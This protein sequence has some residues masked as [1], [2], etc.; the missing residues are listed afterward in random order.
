MVAA[1]SSARQNVRA[2]LLAPPRPHGKASKTRVGPA[3]GVH[4]DWII[5]K[6]VQRCNLNCT[7]CYVYN[8]GD[9]S[10][11]NRPA[12]ISDAVLHTL[13][14]RI[15]EHCSAYSI[16]RFTI[17]LHGGEPLLLGKKRM[18]ALLDLLRQ[19]CEVA[20][21][22]ITL[23]TNGLLLDQEW[24]E[25]FGRN[26]IRFGISCDGPPE[27]AD[28]RRV[29]RDGRGSTSDLLAVIQKL[30]ETGPL[31]DEIGPGI[32]CVVDP[33]SNG[34]EAVR[35]FVQNGFNNFDFLLPDGTHVNR[36]QA[37]SGAAPYKR[38]LLE[39]FEEWCL[40]GVRAPR[41][42]FF[43]LIM[44]GLL[45]IRVSMDYLGG[46][47]RRLCVVESGGS[48][49]LSDLVR[50]CGGIFAH[51]KLNVFDHPLDEVSTHYDL[52]RLQEPCSACQA[53]RYFDACGGGLLPHRFDGQSFGNPSIYCEA[54]YSLADAAFEKLRAELPPSAWIQD[55]R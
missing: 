20:D 41:I 2:S 6:V 8:R 40:M 42:R 36:P 15:S 29:Y 11:K 53:C 45:G 33:T 12:V 27:Q 18:Q 28:R 21:L 49:G 37:W 1:N 3:D 10:W 48:M 25:L 39:A 16:G 31:Y 54:L 30:R 24:L 43:E 9:Q 55:A 19:E 23:Q 32:L 35:W 22:E 46:D 38:F 5:L 7:Y 44:R 13:A 4:I 50:I 52:T 14:R 51:D 26:N 34:A 17:E 47:L